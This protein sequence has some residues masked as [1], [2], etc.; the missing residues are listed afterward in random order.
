MNDSGNP[1][2][3]TE[4]L[5]GSVT[6]QAVSDRR[7]K[8]GTDVPP[9]KKDGWNR[10]P[11]QKKR[12]ERM[13]PERWNGLAWFRMNGYGKVLG[14]PWVG[15][16]TGCPPTKTRS[17]RQKRVGLVRLFLCE[18]TLH[19]HRHT[20][21]SHGNSTCESAQNLSYDKK[22]R[23]LPS[24]KNQNERSRCFAH[25]IVLRRHVLEDSSGG[26]IQTAWFAPNPF[27]KEAN[28]RARVLVRKAQTNTD[29]RRRRP[30]KTGEGMTSPWDQA[31]R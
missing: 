15:K 27:T 26:W 4:D 3:V 21:A 17:T 29:N 14:H 5:L 20:R 22:W 19:F 30:T 9:K 28:Q 2:P 11:T 7:R 10:C 8:A 6:E 1:G 18:V 16:H 12:M 31:V 25:W 24:K 23:R 13:S